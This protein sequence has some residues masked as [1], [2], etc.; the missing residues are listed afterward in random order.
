MKISLLDRGFVHGDA[1][2]DVTR[3]FGHKP[4]KL[5]EHI[6]RLYRSLQYL[7]I[8]P[9]LTA[10]EVEGISLEVLNRNL[11][12]ISQDE[13]YTITQRISRGSSLNPVLE[14]GPPTVAIYNQA[15]S[16]YFAKYYHSGVNLQT[17]TVRRI[18]FE[19]LDPR[20]KTQNRSNNALAEMEA[21]RRDSES[22]PLIL[23]I[24]G[25]IAE[26]AVANFFLVSNGVIKTPSVDNC[27]EG[28]TRDT[29]IELAKKLS[30]P[31]EEKHLQLYDAYTADE[32]FLTTTSYSV[33]PV[34]K[35]D[36]REIG[37]KTPGPIVQSLTEAW[38]DM[39]GV[40]IVTQAEKLAIP[41]KG[42]P[43]SETEPHS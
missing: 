36:G 42:T 34:K 15:I 38:S 17:S 16:F 22:V 10:E 7:R 12:L 4:F 21:K 30:I 14:P 20:A 19:S 26:S 27:L 29:V 9:K 32:A 1:V 6:Q 33:L 35:I 24:D 41:R 40:N 2:F 28:I 5:H 25:N 43:G 37:K 18:P 3:T 13:D 8:D 39:V 11:S 23:D 31:V